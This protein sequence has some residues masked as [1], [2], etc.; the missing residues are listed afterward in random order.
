VLVKVMRG[1]TLLAAVTGAAL[2]V[3]SAG[4]GL[5]GE[6]MGGSVTDAGALSVVDF[7]L[8][9]RAIPDPDTGSASLT[10]RLEA[11]AAQLS[12]PDAGVDAGPNPE[13]L[14]TLGT[15]SSLY[16]D[17]F[18]PTHR[19]GSCSRFSN[20]HGTDAKNVGGSG[21]QAPA[22]IHCDDQKTCWCS[23]NGSDAQG[24][25]VPDCPGDAQRKLARPSDHKN[26]AQSPFFSIVRHCKDDGTAVGIMPREP[27]ASFSGYAIARMKVWIARSAPN[28]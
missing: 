11:R 15:W 24:A 13:A 9:G 10:A 16:A 28:D 4:C 6:I 2:A 20:C 27:D 17:Y 18:G 5:H 8:C 25:H 3:E 7:A 1:L 14:D 23:I 19:D 12:N 21:Y 26:P 22:G